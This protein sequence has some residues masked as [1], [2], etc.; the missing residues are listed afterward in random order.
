MPYEGTQVLDSLVSG[1]NATVWTF[2]GSPP[3][4]LKKD[5]TAG[6]HM[7][8]PQVCGHASQTGNTAMGT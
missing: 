2:I 4:K 8:E 6:L 3:C 5:N 7:G 1:N